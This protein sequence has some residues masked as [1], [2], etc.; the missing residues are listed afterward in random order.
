MASPRV[1]AVVIDGQDWSLNVVVAHGPQK[2]VGEE[3][4]LAWWNDL[5]EIWRQLPANPRGIVL[6]DTNL[7]LGGRG[8][9]LHWPVRPR[10]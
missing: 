7:Q 8:V 3:A 1:L 4:L 2:H 10:S 5:Y 6:A 9:A